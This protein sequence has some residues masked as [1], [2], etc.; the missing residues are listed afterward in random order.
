MALTPASLATIP[1]MAQAVLS[2]LL[3]QPIGP[4]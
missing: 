2:V 1:T 3:D 4:A